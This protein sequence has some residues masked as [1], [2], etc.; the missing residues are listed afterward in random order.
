MHVTGKDNEPLIIVPNK[1]QSKI[2]QKY[3][4]KD[5]PMN[6]VRKVQQINMNKCG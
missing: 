4:C 6:H 3:Y 2:N 5:R 1:K